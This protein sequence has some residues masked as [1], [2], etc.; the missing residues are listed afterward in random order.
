MNQHNA[1]FRP[2]R[3]ITS[4]LFALLMSYYCHSTL[5]F[6][7]S[8]LEFPTV[9]PFSVRS[10]APTTVLVTQQ[11]RHQRNV[12]LNS[13][14]FGEDEDIALDTLSNEGGLRLRL[15]KL[16]KRFL[17]AVK[18]MTI[19]LALSYG[20]R[21][22][23]AEA[24]FSYEIR[25]DR[26][27]S[28]RPGASEE[29]AT[30]W[31]EGEE[32]PEEKPALTTTTALNSKEKQ[33]KEATSKKKKNEAFDYGDDDDFDFLERDEEIRQAPTSSTSRTKAEVANAAKFQ[34]RTAKDFTGIDSSK[35]KSKA[36]YLK[37]SVGLF[38]PTWGAMGVREFVR[39]RKEETYV[40][41]GLEILEAQK[42]ELFGVN[43]TTADS[44]I[45]D[46]LKELKAAEEDDAKDNDEEGL[47]S[48]DEDGD[49]DGDEDDDDDDDGPRRPSKGGPK[50]PSGDG[51]G[52]G[53]STDDNG[54]RPS[55]DDLKKLGDIF[56]RS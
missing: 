18:P 35:S 23:P 44:D 4:L 12:A 55:E 31:S 19:A 13:N 38:I 53:G 56:K 50:K 40:K 7:I 27:Y 26:K 21:L 51:G 42:A 34:E 52:E 48:D 11:F 29:Q 33:A 20:L 45:A 47:D 17:E 25:E 8:G 3:A 10:L 28:I 9:T 37:V 39:R 16:R 41:K 30:Q 32:E 49:E 43:E 54:G 5:G 14:S 6:S 36:L 22:S 1:S 15:R 24:K 46:E 2:P